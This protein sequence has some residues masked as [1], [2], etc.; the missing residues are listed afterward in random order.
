[1]KKVTDFVIHCLNHSLPEADERMTL[2]QEK[3]SHQSYT[4][5]FIY[6]DI[7]IQRYMN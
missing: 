1:M 6:T 2:A 4:I 5:V 7:Y 3:K